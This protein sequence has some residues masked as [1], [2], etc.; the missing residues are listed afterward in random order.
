M[1]AHPEL[2][3]VAQHSL[4]PKGETKVKS[5]QSRRNS[6]NYNTAI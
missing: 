1:R 3:Q 6:V 2:C 4:S 5:N